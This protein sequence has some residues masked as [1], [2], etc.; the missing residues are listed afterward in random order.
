MGEIEKLSTYINV[1]IKGAYGGTNINTQKQNVYDGCDILVA[2]PG[3]LLDLALSGVL[4]LK[5]IQKLVIDEVDEM[6]NLGFRTQLTNLL[7]ILPEKRQNLLFSAT[8]TA[9]VEMVID[10]FFNSPEKFTIVPKGTPLENIEQRVYHVPNFFTKVNL[11]SHLLAT[12]E[13]MTKV[14]IFA[15]SKRL[16]DRLEEKIAEDF[17]KNIG[18]IHSNKSQNYRLRSIDRFQKGDYKILIA[19]DLIAR[20]IDFDDVT[21]VINFDTPDF[22]ENYL[23]RI[24]R[25][26]RAEAKGIAITFVNQ[27]EEEFQVA[28][29]SLMNYQIP[30]FDIPTEV[31]ISEIFTPEEQPNLADKNYL[32]EVT[33][34]GVKVEK[35]KKKAKNEKVNTGGSYREKIKAKYKKPKTRGQ[36]PR[37][38]KK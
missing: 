18:V 2:T 15:E 4:R 10:D 32:P 3:R 38:K 26:G 22:P 34:K 19:T 21:H 1:R 35:H 29:E 25:T 30:T 7:D 31:E 5:S 23:H 8:M 14:L 6:L 24:G 20:G 13:E 33:R 36:K 16:V 27:V 12:D 11:L 37:G 17:E 9:D 28:I